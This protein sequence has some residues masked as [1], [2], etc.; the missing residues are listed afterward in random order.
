VVD[1]GGAFGIEQ[2]R[3]GGDV[4]GRAEGGDAELDEIFGGKRGV[5][6]DDAIERGERFALD[7]ETVT[8]EGN[9]PGGE[10][11]GV[12]SGERAVELEGVT[13]EFDG[14]FDGET[15]RV[16]DFEAKLSGIALG[17]ARKGERESEKEDAEVE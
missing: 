5:D 4:D 15:V 1:G 3:F 11:S 6:F 8:A 10:L 2:R 14:G 7:L 12:V 9:I 13:G 17:F 16:S